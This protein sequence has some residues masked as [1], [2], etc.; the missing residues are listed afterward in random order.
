MLIV[1]SALRN[2]YYTC[3]ITK[4]N[5]VI[6][7]NHGYAEHENNLQARKSNNTKLFRY[8]ELRGINN[9]LYHSVVVNNQIRFV[10]K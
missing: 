3:D 2:N 8:N 5:N 1:A 10:K 6:H 9:C 7:Q 4:T